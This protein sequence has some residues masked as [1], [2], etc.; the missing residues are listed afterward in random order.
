M[1]EEVYKQL[2]ITLE[3]RGGRYPAKD[4]PEFYEMAEELFSPEEAA[5]TNAMPKGPFTPAMIAGNLHMTKDNVKAVLEDMTDKG[6]CV[7]NTSIMP[8]IYFGPPLMPGIME[9]QFLRG[10]HTERDKKLA[11]LIHHYKMV[12]D[13]NGKNAKRLFPYSR[14]ITVDR[15]IKTG[16]TVHTYDQVATYI[17]N[18]E[19]IAVATCFCRQEAVLVDEN[20]LCEKPFETCFGFGPGAQ[21][22]IERGMGRKVTKDEAMEILRKSEEAGLIHTTSNVQEPIIFLCNCCACHCQ[23]IRESLAQ[24][25]PGDVFMSGF[26]PS[27]DLYLCTVCETC[28]DRCPSKALCFNDDNELKVDMDQ[29]FGCGLCATGC[30]SDAIEMVRKPDAPEPPANAKDLARALKDINPDMLKGMPV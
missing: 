6:L 16:N 21:N 22:V 26:Q 18:Y 27:I 11:R 2:F 4:I 29:C 24:P 12:I 28:I 9:L 13:G 17:Q 8:D 19:I 1:A 10:T 30:I 5:V 23:E 14:V 7:G 3:K 20:D 25:K 15:K